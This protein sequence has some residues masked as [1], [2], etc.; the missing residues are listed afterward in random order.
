VANSVPELRFISVAG[1]MGP[2]QLSDIAS[3]TAAKSLRSVFGS[4]GGSSGSP[5]EVKGRLVAGFRCAN[6]TIGRHPSAGTDAG[7]RAAMVA[8][9]FTGD[10]AVVAAVGDVQC[11]RL[12][13][14]RL[15]SLRTLTEDASDATAEPYTRPS[16]YLDGRT[17]LK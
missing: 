1:G 17:L 16:R 7:L 6:E 3:R 5:P 8:A 4:L 12:R 2:A 14:G 13:D 11:Y 9:A 15:E 10:R